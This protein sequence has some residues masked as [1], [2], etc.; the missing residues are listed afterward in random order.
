MMLPEELL[1]QV[2][3]VFLPVATG[4]GPEQARRVA[5]EL[6]ERCDALS[7]PA[8]HRYLAW[9]S[10][11]RFTNSLDRLNDELLEFDKDCAGS[12]Q[13]GLDVAAPTPV[14]LIRDDV[15]QRLPVMQ[16]GIAFIVANF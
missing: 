16:L 9:Q 8:Q 7:L 14:T 10:A 5:M 11:Q 12:M 4:A 6:F 2:V 3:H 15:L 13:P 1:Q